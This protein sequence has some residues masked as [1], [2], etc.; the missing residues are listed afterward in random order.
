MGA[1]GY[2][3][4]MSTSTITACPSCG[5]KNRVPA[6]AVGTP[7]CAK[8]KNSLPWVVHACGTIFDS[9]VDTRVPVIV[10]LWA[11]WCAPCRTISPILEKVALERA[12]AIKLVKV[13]VDDCPETAAKYEARSIPTL[14]ILRDG[15]EVS[16][17]VGAVPKSQLDAWLTRNLG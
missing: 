16:R 15:N 17:Q 7:R 13:N 8:C 14:L 4:V 11:P 5:T 2:G 3:G 1:P 10:D 9:V 12:G 6:A